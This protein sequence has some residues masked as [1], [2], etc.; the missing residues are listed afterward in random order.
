MDFLNNIDWQAQLEDHWPTLASYGLKALGAFLVLIIGLR[1]SG[2]MASF[3]RKQA[4]KRPNID[5]T[6]GSFFAS[7]VR[8]LMTAATLIA[9][10]QL[11]GVQAT[12]F[13]AILGAMTLAIGLSLQGALGNIASGIMIMLF[14]PYG[15]GQYIDIAGIGGTVKEINLFQTI[16]A[17]PDNVQ[18]IVP[19][20][21]AIDGIIKNYSGYST[22]RI[23][24]V[25]GIDYGDGMEN[26][27]N[28]IESVIKAD[29]RVLA[30]PAPV[31]RVSELNSSSVD[32]IARPWVKTPDYWETRWALIQAVKSALDEAGISIPY[33]HQVNVNKE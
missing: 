11:F 13:V 4:I 12:S 8:W 32:I 6:L 23:D 31:V 15:V 33:P 29:K 25:F 7:L 9:A 1:I 16:L 18:V 17:T 2:A 27:M 26:A 10:L 28:V 19:N 20:S 30:D 3:V 22:R 14:R 24:L 21:Q 5:E